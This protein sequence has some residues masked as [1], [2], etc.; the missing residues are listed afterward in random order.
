MGKNNNPTT[1]EFTTSLKKILLGATHHSQFLICLIQDDSAIIPFSSSLEETFITNK[2]GSDSAENCKV[3]EYFESLPTLS[4]YKSDII[5]YIAGYV[6]RQIL[7]K[8][9]CIHC[10]LFL[11]NMKIVQTSLILDVKNRGPLCIPS[12]EVVKIVKVTHS[13]VEKRLRQPHLLME[14]NIVEKLT[15]QSI[16]VLYNLTPDLLNS[17]SEHAESCTVTSDH[18]VKPMRK[19]VSFYILIILHHFCRSHN[20][21][22][23]KI[24]SM[25]SKLILFKNQ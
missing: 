12:A 15:I 3:E 9:Q 6:Q 5:V 20:N 23:D 7:T 22:D 13:V 17:L 8:E 21:K 10:K 24:R 16:R 19:I 1:K 4:E 2:V 14:R 18:R 25:Y 11:T